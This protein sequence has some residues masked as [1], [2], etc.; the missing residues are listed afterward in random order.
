LG[1]V[2]E[3][4]CSATEAE[5]L[6]DNVAMLGAT[7]DLRNGICTLVNAG[8]PPPVVYSEGERACRRVPL[9]GVP[10]SSASDRSRRFDN[11]H[12]ELDPGDTIVFVTDGIVE[13]SRFDNPYGYRFMTLVDSMRGSSARGIGQAIL[14]D[15]NAHPRPATVADDATL[16]VAIRH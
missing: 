15:W 13:T 12:V 9:T 14:A 10:L 16:V 2:F 1:D 8:L 7:L 6:F 3:R 4:I 11:R 5:G